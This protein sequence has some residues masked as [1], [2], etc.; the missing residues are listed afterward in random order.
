MRA[1]P[2]SPDDLENAER[3]RHPSWPASACLPATYRPQAGAGYVATSGPT[4][5]AGVSA[6]PRGA[7][8]IP[9]PSPC[10]ARSPAYPPPHA[11]IF[12]L[13]S[14]P[15]PFFSY[16]RGRGRSHHCA[17]AYT[18]I[19]EGFPRLTFPLLLLAFLSISKKRLLSGEITHI[20]REITIFR[21]RRC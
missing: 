21:G 20:S 12:P 9:P 19:R 1:M 17:S 16:H 6:P 3:D 15:P 4:G 14:P 13:P 8:A 7:V 11:C 5:A 2:P 18:Y 10:W